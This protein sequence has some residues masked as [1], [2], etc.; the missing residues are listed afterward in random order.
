[1]RPESPGAEPSGEPCPLVGLY[2]ACERDGAEGLRFC[3]EFDGALEYGGCVLGVACEL[4]TLDV[5]EPCELVDGVPTRTPS[6]CDD[7][8]EGG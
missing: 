7:P 4:S 2:V 6:P 8:P 5:C 1:M 3:D